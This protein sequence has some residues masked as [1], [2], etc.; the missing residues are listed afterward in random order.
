[1]KLKFL[2]ILFALAGGLAQA[3]PL[4]ED[5]IA[6][7]VAQ[8]DFVMNAG[9]CAVANSRTPAKGEVI[10]VLGPNGWVTFSLDT[11]IRMRLLGYQKTADG[12]WQMSVNIETECRGD[13]NS[14]G[15]RLAL[16]YWKTVPPNVAKPGKGVKVK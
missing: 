11:Y 6:A 14:E 10:R 8:N 1:M 9:L 16:L 15:C 12:R 13:A 7:M 3:A 4:P 5:K 2:A